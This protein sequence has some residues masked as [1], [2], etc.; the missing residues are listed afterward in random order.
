M[1]N[2]RLLGSHLLSHQLGISSQ[3]IPAIIGP[4]PS[5]VSKESPHMHVEIPYHGELAESAFIFCPF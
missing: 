5:L 3:E 2:Q 4:D 1:F